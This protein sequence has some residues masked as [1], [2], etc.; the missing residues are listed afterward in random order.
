MIFP[1]Y[2]LAADMVMAAFVLI[3][4]FSYHAEAKVLQL[5]DDMKSR[6]RA[7][8][9][10]RACPACFPHHQGYMLPHSER[11]FQMARGEHCCCCYI[12][13]AG[14]I[15]YRLIDIGHAR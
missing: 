13:I 14:F 12:E 15:G 2:W 11:K 6:T 4:S 8:Y 1:H 5:A 10:Y 9:P 7:R 3:D